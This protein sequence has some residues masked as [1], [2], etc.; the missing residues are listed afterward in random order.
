MA[1]QEV[2]VTTQ[3]DD[4]SGMIDRTTEDATTLGT[5]DAAEDARRAG[6][7]RDDDWR[8]GTVEDGAVGSSDP[9]L[10]TDDGVPVVSTDFEADRA[11][12]AGDDDAVKG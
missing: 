8:R 2:T 10:A 1:T 5:A 9:D 4:D 6:A 12:A 7:G 3:P 11:R